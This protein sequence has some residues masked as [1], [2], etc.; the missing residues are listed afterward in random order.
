VGRFDGDCLGRI[1]ARAAAEPKDHVR[2]EIPGHPGPGRYNIG[3]RVGDDP[4]EMRLGYS[5]LG[6]HSFDLPEEASK[7]GGIGHGHEQAP[8]A[9]TGDRG[10]DFFQAAAAEPDFRWLVIAE[11]LHD[12]S[13]LRMML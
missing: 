7:L 2:F 8:A 11:W 6:Q 5:G 3:G 13:I 1:Y 9:Q 12:L 4:S 10:R